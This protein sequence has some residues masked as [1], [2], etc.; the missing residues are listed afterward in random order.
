MIHH[1]IGAVD[2]GKPIV[3]KEVECRPGESES[4]LSERIHQVEWKAVVEGV[5]IVLKE[6]EDRRRNGGA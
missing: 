4:E 1:V 6:L 2:E 3:V 5:A